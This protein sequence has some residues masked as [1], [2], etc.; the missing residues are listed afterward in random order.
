M[1]AFALMAAACGGSTAS[2]RLDE[3]TEQ[4]NSAPPASVGSD[5]SGAPSADADAEEAGPPRQE[6]GQVAEVGGEA[7]PYLLF[8]QPS[9]ARR[10]FDFY[11]QN[12]RP[13]N[14][15]DIALYR[16]TGE[17]PAGTVGPVPG[18]RWHVNP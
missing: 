11:N 13:N 8:L 7:D 1:G 17:L 6:P 9:P 12:A 18:A 3:T 5:E 14:Q 4:H 16:Q 10:F 15:W 2:D